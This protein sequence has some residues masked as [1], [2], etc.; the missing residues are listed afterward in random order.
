[1]EALAKIPRRLSLLCIIDKLTC[2]H[3]KRTIGPDIQLQV[4]A[5]C[6]SFGYEK[7]LLYH[8]GH[9]Y[10]KTESN[11]QSVH[12]PEGYEKVDTLQHH[13]ARLSTLDAHLVLTLTPAPL[14]PSHPIFHMDPTLTYL[15][16]QPH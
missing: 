10:V 12:F 2:Q 4:A 7:C 5:V 11:G 16:T 9:L 1:M 6:Y 13:C 3:D 15:L 14:T 8:N